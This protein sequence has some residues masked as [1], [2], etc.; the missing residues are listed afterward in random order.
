MLRHVGG[1]E[2]RTMRR[3]IVGTLALALAFAGAAPARSDPPEY[4][5][6]RFLATPRYLLA[7][8]DGSEES[9]I[10]QATDVLA[11][12]EQLATALDKEFVAA[13]VVKEKDLPRPEA[14]KAYETNGPERLALPPKKSTLWNVRFTRTR[15]EMETA[16][17][18]LPAAVN[19]KGTA[20]YTQDKDGFL[21]VVAVDAETKE[22]MSWGTQQHAFHRVGLWFRRA[23][24]PPGACVPLGYSHF[25]RWTHVAEGRDFPLALGGIDTSYAEKV[26]KRVAD[27]DATFP[28]LARLF[29]ATTKEFDDDPMTYY[30][31][32]VLFTEFLWEFSPETRKHYVRALAA[33]GKSG[34]PVAAFPLKTIADELRP[35]FKTDKELEDAFR[36]FV[37]EQSALVNARKNRAK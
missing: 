30:G 26:R 9:E 32:S 14:S 17:A 2:G 23:D 16:C 5:A 34:R 1:P 28:S 29:A 31:A 6:V 19:T 21:G 13:G 8:P 20:F 24:K 10:V 4:A 15:A 7:L 11:T 37:V 3:T 27:S 35:I 36:K 25:M 22:L 18:A 33:Y 12:L